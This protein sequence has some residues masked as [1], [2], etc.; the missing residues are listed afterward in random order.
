[1]SKRRDDLKIEVRCPEC[2]IQST[3]ESVSQF[4]I[5][6]ALMQI[7]SHDKKIEVSLDTAE[8]T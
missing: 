1:M 6:M 8:I 2:G 7:L 5:N 3:A 4:T